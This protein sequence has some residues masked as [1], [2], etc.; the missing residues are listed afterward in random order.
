MLINTWATIDD[1]NI[2]FKKWTR[3]V[4]LVDFINLVGLSNTAYQPPPLELSFIFIYLLYVVCPLLFFCCC[5][6]E[7]QWKLSPNP[8]PFLSFFSS[9]HRNPDLN[10]PAHYLNTFEM[11]FC[12]II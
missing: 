11:F 7:H 5:V 10:I 6:L 9:I 12:C 3:S 1:V 4:V 8:A 2:T